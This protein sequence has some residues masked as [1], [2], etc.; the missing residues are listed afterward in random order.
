MKNKYFI[1]GLV[2]VLVLITSFVQYNKTDNRKRVAFPE[3]Y[4]S[5]THVKSVVVTKS[6][7]LYDR[8]GGIHHIYANDKALT[9]LKDDATF[10]K[11][12]V[13]IF[14]L[15]KEIV[16]D[17]LIYEGSRRS[18]AVMLKDVDRFAETGGWGFEEFIKD[19]QRIRIV[20]D[21]NKQCF[22]CHKSQ[23]VSDYVYSKY[24]D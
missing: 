7:S 1:S 16:R 19:D 12:S 23:K 11:G 22:S 4:R 8:F 13:L 15:K 6:H 2:I 10:E 3:G 20:T 18:V 5:W 17:S 24:R 9:S 14:D 21:A